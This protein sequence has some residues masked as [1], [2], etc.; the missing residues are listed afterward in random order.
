LSLD[1]LNT[2]KF[3]PI[4]TNEAFAL[5]Q[6]SNWRSAYLDRMN[7]IPPAD[8][9]R[10]KVINQT[11]VGL[12]LISSE[13]LVR[14]YSVD[15]E[16]SKYKTADQ[17]IRS[18]GEAAVQQSREQR[19]ALKQQKK[20]EAAERKKAHDEAVK[21]RKSTDIVF[22]GRGV[23][24]GLANRQSHIEKLNQAG[25]PVLATPADLSKALDVSIPQLKWLAF[26]TVAATQVHYV[27]FT[28]PK[29]SGGERTL[30]APHRKLAAAQ[31][32]IFENVLQKVQPHAAANG[33]VVGR[34]VVT[35][36]QPHVG[37]D[38]VVN[39]D[40]KDFFPSPNALGEK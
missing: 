25:L 37:A 40:L 34:S 10:I 8:V 36:A 3:A 4:S 7:I 33:F 29:K 30:S 20:D 18:A 31:R 21:L 16:F 15:E 14:I 12:G 22:L 23:S 24:K 26:H 35:N 2:D 28:I 32:W 13:E 27:S 19:A 39:A 9:P 5:T 17:Q 11:M 1:G 6:G 38:V